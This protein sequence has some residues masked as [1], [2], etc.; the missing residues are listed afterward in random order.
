M[1]TFAGATDFGNIEGNRFFVVISNNHKDNLSNSPI[2]TWKSRALSSNET[3]DIYILFRA[4][5][6]WCL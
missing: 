1:L 2:L 4:F 6:R 3:R 5:L